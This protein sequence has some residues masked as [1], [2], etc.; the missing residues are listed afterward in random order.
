[1]VKK[2][3]EQEFQCKT[4]VCAAILKKMYGTYYKISRS[5][6]VK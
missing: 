4:C 5:I 3:M 6:G 1:M 2:R